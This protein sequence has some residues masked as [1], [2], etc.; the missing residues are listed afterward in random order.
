MNKKLATTFCLLMLAASVFAQT[1]KEILDK[2]AARF[3]KKT[4]VTAGFTAENFEGGSS[5]GRVTGSIVIK[6]QDFMVNASEYKTWFNGKTQWTYLK[7]NEEVNVSN[8]TADELAAMNPY[9]FINLY[10]EGYTSTVKEVKL[11]GKDCYEIHLKATSNKKIR[12]ALL[13]IS[14]DDY[15]PL[16]IRFRQGKNQW[17]RLTVNSFANKSGVKDS[18]FVFDAKEYPKAEII[19]L[20]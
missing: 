18:D 20:R 19:D 1:A 11:R 4:A 13:T 5:K 12:E 9:A 14:K 3:S 7:A 8:P 15:A 17:T 6:G 2:T 10:K 16:S